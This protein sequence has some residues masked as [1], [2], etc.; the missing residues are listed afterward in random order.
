MAGTADLVQE[1]NSVAVI[2]LGEAATHFNPEWNQSLGPPATQVMVEQSGALFAGAT[3]AEA[4]AQAIEDAVQRA[5][6]Q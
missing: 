3:T 5:A 6:D 2:E 4:A 1:P